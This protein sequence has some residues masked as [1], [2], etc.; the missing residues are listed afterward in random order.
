MTETKIYAMFK[1]RKD[2]Y[3]QQIQV[4]NELFYAI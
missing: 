1:S 3:F 4:R 2:T